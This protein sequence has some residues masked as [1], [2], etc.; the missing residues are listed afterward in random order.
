MYRGMLAGRARH[1]RSPA[2][3]RLYDSRWHRAR[4]VFL[5]AHPLCVMCEQVG[6]TT[7]A[8]VV[9]HIK[10]HKGDAALFWDEGNWQSLCASCH[11]RHKQ[12]QERTGM[13]HGASA[14]GTPLDPAHPWRGEG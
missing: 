2:H 3:K 12:R 7:P 13:A 9:D 5:A 14:D 4:R 10:M 1:G 8:S 6:R 11:D